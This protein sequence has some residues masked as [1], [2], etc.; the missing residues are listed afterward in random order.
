MPKT[1]RHGI[2][3]SETTAPTYICKADRFISNNGA[4]DISLLIM[5]RIKERAASGGNPSQPETTG[6]N[7]SLALSSSPVSASK[8]AKNTAISIG[9]SAS[10]KNCFTRTKNF[11]K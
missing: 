4:T 7:T 2:Y 11:L 9:P 3:K 1:E 5:P 8:A 10:I 6:F